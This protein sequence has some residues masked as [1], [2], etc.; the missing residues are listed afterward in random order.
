MGGLSAA[1]WE[2]A[3]AYDDPARTGEV[4]R[5]ARAAAAQAAAVAEHAGGPLLVEIAGQVRS[6]AVD[7][8]R[9]AELVAHAAPAPEDL[10]T[11]ELLL[12][13][14]VATRGGAGQAARRRGASRWTPPSAS[15]A[16]SA[17]VRP[18]RRTST[19]TPHGRW[20]TR[21]SASGQPERMRA[22]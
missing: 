7:L 19:I 17:I 3:A 20:W 6:T 10:P 21:M 1:V 18:D 14:S 13:P 16:T 15:K 5:K 9:A 22:M 11:E 12:A 4:T 2:L 8:V